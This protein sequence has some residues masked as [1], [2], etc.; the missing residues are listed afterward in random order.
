V[1][2]F[3]KRKDHMM[4]LKWMVPVIL[5]STLLAACGGAAG[6]VAATETETTAD[7]FLFDE[8]GTGSMPI[9]S[10]LMLGTLLLEET[11]LAV[12]SEQASELLPLWKAVRS[13]GESDTAAAAE[14][15]AV[16]KQIQETMTSEQLETI[17]TMEI[18]R[19][20]MTALMEELGVTRGFGEGI[21]DG[22]DF[23]PPEGFAG[24][25]PEGGIPGGGDGS[26]DRGF[27]G[28]LNPEQMATMQAMRE[29]RGGQAGMFGAQLLLDPLIE[30]LESKVG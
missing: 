7:T 18:S 11:E 5:I 25:P 13:L 27:G 21:G 16:I 3:Y 10:Q 24:R 23:Q 8:G 19:E 9:Q 29:K 17:T 2:S 12:D 15:E 1:K 26:G 20:D 4:K 6:E 14:I 28:D 30:L 22:S